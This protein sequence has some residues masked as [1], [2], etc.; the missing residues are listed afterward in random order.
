LEL[1]FS[2]RLP[3]LWQDLSPVGKQDNRLAFIK[4]LTVVRLLTG[5]IN[6]LSESKGEL[7]PTANGPGLMEHLLLVRRAV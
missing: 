3:L 6:G 2:E 5:N 7:R 1:S 4:V